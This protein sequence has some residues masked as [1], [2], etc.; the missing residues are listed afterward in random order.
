MSTPNPEPR[1]VI[2]PHRPYARVLLA[3][4]LLLWVGSLVATWAWATRVAAPGLDKVEAD[5]ALA[6]RRAKNAEALVAQLR[7]NIATLRRSDQISRA[8]NAELQ[9][10]LAEREEEVSGLRADV[11]FYERLVGAT[12]QRRGLTVHEAVFAPEAGGAWRYTLTLTQNL[13]RGA[14]SKGEARVSVEG[15]RDGKLQTL[16]WGELLQQPN[17]PGQPFS[18]RYF[19]Q[20]EGSV[21][22]PSGFT[23][24]RVRV[25]LRADGGTVEQTF[26][27]QAPTP[28]GD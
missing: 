17:A 6:A 10:S 27:W 22:L 9:A 13:N 14:I 2:V 23:P 11:A 26:P 7:Q 21:M 3:V 24:Q 20:L 15:V 28:R 8:A 25:Q 12:G 4:V 16:A 18:F 1:F 5:L 19:Q